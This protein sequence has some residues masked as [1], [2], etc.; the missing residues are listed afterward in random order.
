MSLNLLQ[1]V[2]NDIVDYALLINNQIFLNN[3]KF[4]LRVFLK[5]TLAMFWTQ[6]E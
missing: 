3:E 2:V 4:N 1:Y 5:E 6:A